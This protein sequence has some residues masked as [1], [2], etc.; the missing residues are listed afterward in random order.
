MF[1]TEI[2]KKTLS[3]GMV[4]DGFFLIVNNFRGNKH[5]LKL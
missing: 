1:K 4:L 2:G 3:N 5:I